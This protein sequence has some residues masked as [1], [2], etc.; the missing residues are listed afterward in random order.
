MENNMNVIETNEVESME[1]QVVETKAEGFVSKVVGGVKKHG[2]TI[3]KGVGI[4]ALGIIAY[5]IGKKSGKIEVYEDYADSETA[6]EF[7][8]VDEPE[9]EV[10]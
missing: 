2:K 1:G 6:V 4:A 10:E 8:V 9:V 3:L 7:E 5:G